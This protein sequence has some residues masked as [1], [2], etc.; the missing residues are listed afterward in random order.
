MFR[1]SGSKLSQPASQP[2][3]QPA[4]QP[5]NHPTSQPDER[6]N[7][8][9]NERT[10]TDRH[11]GKIE[12]PASRH[13][14]SS[15]SNSRRERKREILL[16][17]P[18]SLA[19]RNPV[20][21]SCIVKRGIP[22][23][24][25]HESEEHKAPRLPLTRIYAYPI[26]RRPSPQTRSSSLIRATMRKET[27]VSRI[28]ASRFSWFLYLFRVSN[29]DRIRHLIVMDLPCICLLPSKHSLRL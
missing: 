16:F 18:P 24:G 7:E 20:Y 23:F 15:I 9:T 29:A 26:L 14:T 25:Y 2:V 19:R 3:S 27:A 12:L 6:T 28:F 4:S 13:T 1:C 17:L 22:P 10:Y 8:R 11:T 21:Q 5:A